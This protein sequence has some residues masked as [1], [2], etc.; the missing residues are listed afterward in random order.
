METRVLQTA[1]NLAF[2]RVIK[3]SGGMIAKGG[4]L[5]ILQHKSDTNGETN[6]S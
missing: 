5:W 3:S 4:I 1:N 6:E 2:L